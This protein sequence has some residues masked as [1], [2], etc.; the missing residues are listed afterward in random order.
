MFTSAGSRIFLKG[1]AEMAFGDNTEFQRAFYARF[2]IG[3]LTTDGELAKRYGREMAATAEH[4]E[5]CG[6]VC[7][8]PAIAC[9]R[10]GLGGMDEPDQ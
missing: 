2:P 1:L 10:D 9:V 7:G 8:G 6:R 4:G 5:F 3:M